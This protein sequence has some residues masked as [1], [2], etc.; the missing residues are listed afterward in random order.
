MKI[1]SRKNCFMAGLPQKINSFSK[2]KYSKDGLK[3]SCKNCG[4]VYREDNKEHIKL[5][6]KKY[7]EIN[8]K[9]ISE[10]NK[11][12]RLSNIGHC[13]VVEKNY[14]KKNRETILKKQRDVRETFEGKQSR[15][16]TDLKT[17]YRKSLGW[18]YTKLDEQDGGCGICSS[19]KS[20]RKTYENFCV[21]HDHKCCMGS[22]SCG[23]CVR[24]LLCFP[25]N[26]YLGHLEI[27][28][29]SDLLSPA[30]LKYLNKYKK[31]YVVQN[32]ELKEA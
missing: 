27:K 16:N 28:N 5:Q 15:R 1:C 23:E 7:S 18:Y 2:S 31:I 29:N 14:R 25:C 4:K 3:C 26:T 9:H 24:G 17:K 8:K 6:S 12:R 13:L 19:K 21:D 10:K 20:G 22:K 30:Q 32:K 11:N